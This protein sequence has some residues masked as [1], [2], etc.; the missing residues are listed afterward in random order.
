MELAHGVGLGQKEICIAMLAASEPPP[1]PMPL[2][3]QEAA[4]A[5]ASGMEA[6]PV[7]SVASASLASVAEVAYAFDEREHAWAYVLAKKVVRWQSAQHVPAVLVAGAA[8]WSV[9]QLAAMLGAWQGMIAAAALGV[10]STGTAIFRLR[11]M[12]VER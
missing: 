7:A 10:A 12:A 3:A 9:L 2:Q 8:V 1:V 6:R 5:Q 4:A 11:Q